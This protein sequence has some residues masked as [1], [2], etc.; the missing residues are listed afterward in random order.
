[1]CP[2]SQELCLALVS[3][4]VNRLLLLDIRFDKHVK[5]T[6]SLGNIYRGEPGFYE[7][8]G[9]RFIILI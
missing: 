4:K 6:M 2:Q 5:L 7:C 3:K 9:L 1:M 8:W